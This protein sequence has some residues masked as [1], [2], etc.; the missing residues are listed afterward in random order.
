MMSIVEASAYSLIVVV[1]ISSSLASGF[2]FSLKCFS[3][4]EI[5]LFLLERYEV[6][7]E[8]VLSIQERTLNDSFSEI[9]GLVFCELDIFIVSFFQ[10]VFISFLLC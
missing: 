5:E 6:R 9:D 2:D 10:F 7:D 1:S 4:M 3:R 8:I